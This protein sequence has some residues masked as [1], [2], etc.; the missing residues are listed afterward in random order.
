MTVLPR[1]VLGA[2]Q[3]SCPVL[4]ARDRAALVCWADPHE[5]ESPVLCSR[6]RSTRAPLHGMLTLN[7]SLVIS[8]NAI[9]FRD[10][11]LA[12]REHV[13]PKRFSVRRGNWSKTGLSFSNCP[14][15]RGATKQFP[16]PLSHGAESPPYVE[17][18]PLPVTLVLPRGAPQM[19]LL[20]NDERHSIPQLFSSRLR[21]LASFPVKSL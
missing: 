20:R 5:R 12:Y 8:P 4:V 3:G 13:L 17:V 14:R 18:R 11:A 1:D 19:L 10:Y 15:R 6:L 16:A 7:P 9:W 2:K 21:Q